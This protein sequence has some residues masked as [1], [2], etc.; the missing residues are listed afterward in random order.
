MSN[1]KRKKKLPQV[2]GSQEKINDWY[3]GS[4]TYTGTRI[5]S[6]QF[7]QQCRSEIFI[8][9]VDKIPGNPNTRQVRVMPGT[10]A[11]YLRL[12]TADT[13]SRALKVERQV[14]PEE[15][16]RIQLSL[17]KVKKQQEEIGESES[18]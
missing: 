6:E 15:F 3:V 14:S 18:A 8:S 17:Q 11:Q 5:F 1:I 9:V 16:R 12:L 7:Y 10:Q 13:A 2:Q 4:L